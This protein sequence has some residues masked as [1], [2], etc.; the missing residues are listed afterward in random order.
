MVYTE[1]IANQPPET[2]RILMIEKITLH[3]NGSQHQ[4]E[5]DPE[6]PLLYV[7][8]SQLSLWGVKTACGQ[9]QCGACNVLID[10]EAVPSCKLHVGAVQGS[11]IVTIE[12][13]GTPEELHPLQE[14]FV[15]E[16]ATQCG[17]CTVGMIIAAQGLL[18]KVRYPSEAQINQ[19]LDS[20][21]CRCGTHERVRRAIKLRIARPEGHPLFKTL[22]L[23]PLPSTQSSLPNALVQNPALD[24]WIRIN[25]DGT[26]TV[27]SGKVEYGQGIKSAIAQIAADEL[28]V[29]LA[30]IRMQMADT[31]QT[32]DEGRTV[33]SMSLETSGNAVRQAAAEARQFLLYRSLEELEA[34][35]EDLTVE[36][37]T[38][39]NT[40]NGRSI[41]YWALQGGQKF[42]AH[43][44]GTAAP[45]T[46]AEYSLVGNPEKRLDLVGKTT[47]THP[48][49]HDLHPD[50]MLHG[51][52]VRPPSYHARL[53]AVD[54]APVEQLPGVVKV[55]QDSSF[56][57]VIAEEEFQA[58]RAL[59]ALTELAEWETVP[60]PSDQ[61][62]LHE[63]IQ[64][65][66]DESHLVVDGSG[67]Y[68]PIPPIRE[69]AGASQTVQATYTKPYHM[70]ATI[71]PS[72]ALALM[73]EGK[74]TLRSHTQGAFPPRDSIA[75]VLDMNPE[76]IHVIHTEGSGTY[77]HNGA[78]DAALDAALL[79]RSLPGRPV[80]LRWTRANEH[81]WE[82]YSPAAVLKLQ[83]S[84]NAQGE[85][86]SWNHD[87]YSPPHLGR[88]GAEPGTSA[89]LAAEYLENPL[90]KPPYR[91]VMWNNVGAH[92]NADPLY[93]FPEKR[94]VRHTQ[95]HPALRVSSFRGLGAYANVFAIE[96]F[97]DEL[98]AAAGIDPV[99]FRLRHL[100]DR[101]A[102]AVIEAVGD[103]AGW[104]QPQPADHGR[105]IAFA[106]YKNRAAYCAVVVELHIDRE[107]GRIQL[108]HAY[109]A[110]EAGQVVNPD[111][112]SNQLEGGLIQSASMTLK[113]QVTYT[114]EG[115]TSVD[116]ETYPI[117]TFSEA[118]HIETVILNRPGAPFMGAG[119]ASIGP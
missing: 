8:R 50:G 93:N 60:I 39:T 27:F 43:I 70:H 62:H 16:Q 99:A 67:T 73:Q 4:I 21:L 40:Q 117:L 18:N 107:S 65:Q 59:E 68:D 58:D 69:P 6:T 90:P 63:E 47:G 77:G 49:V 61:A 42:N 86:I 113:E 72:A 54:T 46:P 31:A 71:A 111:G 100:A 19:A 78:D 41:T 17:Y 29:S 88:S 28:D 92:R 95:I 105:G 106:Q 12:G 112:L 109:I 80:L 89:M 103:K 116:W 98:A 5:A 83:A 15:E 87:V 115:I 20:H 11:Q 3:V 96:S 102:R 2:E 25:P 36:D 82:P 14:A 34:A 51:R 118:P 104:G 13:L 32:P 26:I 119:E 56:L 53:K 45:K 114:A 38:I 23:P 10:G 9:E 108:D 110:G 52:V 22:D 81:Q 1:C 66:I 44:S 76:D 33:G 24:A 84:L 75:V 48:Y 57:G 94:I 79:V 30:R 97:M 91:S 37:G 101:R 35:P 64:G 74:L 55:V 7:L 85:V